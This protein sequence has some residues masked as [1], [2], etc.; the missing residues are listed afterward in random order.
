MRPLLA[1][2]GIYSCIGTVSVCAEAVNDVLK[3]FGLVGT[4][5]PDCSKDPAKEAASR[6]VY[7]LSPDGSAAY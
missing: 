7:T 3:E 4:W 1:A 6:V 5:S 2:V